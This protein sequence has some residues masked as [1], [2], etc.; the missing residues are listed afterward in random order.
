MLVWQKARE[1]AVLVCKELLP[2][3]PSEE[4]YALG[5]QLR[6]SVQSVPANIAEAYG[7]YSFQEAIRF[8]YIARGSLEETCS[9]L[10]LTMDLEYSPI[11]IISGCID[12]YKET[13]R[14]LNGYIDYLKRSRK[15]EGRREVK[16]AD[17]EWDY[18]SSMEDH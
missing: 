2:Q 3:L 9:Y 5:Q 16:D 11:D 1:L 12:K 10:I 6:R 8:L 15:G 14:L 18:E 13:A 17:W 4:K 7:R